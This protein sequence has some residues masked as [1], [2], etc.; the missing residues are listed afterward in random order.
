MQQLLHSNVDQGRSNGLAFGGK[1]RPTL[2][3]DSKA[4]AH[5]P[6]GAIQFRQFTSRG[7]QF[8]HDHI[9]FHISLATSSTKV[10]S[11]SL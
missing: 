5:L 1:I 6:L 4:L 7:P 3:L 11:G 2:F 8:Q 9:L 10:L